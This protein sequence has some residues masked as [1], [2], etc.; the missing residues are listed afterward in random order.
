MESIFSDYLPLITFIKIN[1]YY[2]DRNYCKIFCP[3]RLG[4]MEHDAEELSIK[5]TGSQEPVKFGAYFFI[6][7]LSP[8]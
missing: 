3:V 2:M 6:D 7:N 1:H 8:L 5:K 4:F